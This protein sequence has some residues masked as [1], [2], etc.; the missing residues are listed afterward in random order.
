MLG[1]AITH[2]NP[3]N[4]TDYLQYISLFAVPYLRHVSASITPSSGKLI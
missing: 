1:K 3:D 2:C 4:F